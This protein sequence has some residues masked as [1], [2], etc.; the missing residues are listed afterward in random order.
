[1]AV[2]TFTLSDVM[3][4]CED[5]AQLVHQGKQA[6]AEEAKREAGPLFAEF[7]AV[8]GRLEEAN[9]QSTTRFERNTINLIDV[10]HAGVVFSIRV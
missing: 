3:R 8:P 1:M 5:I 9:A 6:A 10:H 7:F 4:S 2:I